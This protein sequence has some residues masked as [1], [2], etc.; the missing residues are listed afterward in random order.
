MTPVNRRISI[1]MLLLIVSAP[2]R[3]WRPETR[4]ELA[5]E[6]LRLMPASLRLVLEKQRGQVRRGMLAPMVDEDGPEHRPPWADGSLEARLTEEIEGLIE[7]LR[8]ERPAFQDIAVRF[9]RV[10]HYVADAGFPPGVSRG[11]ATGRFAHFS[12]FCESRR[13]RFP[14][15][16]YGHQDPDLARYDYRAYALGV[17]RRAASED[18][19]LAAAYARAG[20]PPDPAA[21][22]DRS[23]PFAVGSLAYS[24]SFTDIV[25]V[26]LHVWR[27]A[28]GDVGR[29]PYL[30]EQPTLK[31]QPTPAQDALRDGG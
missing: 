2:I 3:A 31:K 26:W 11:D 12:S 1:A 8:R 22:D 4:L 9:G 6:A 13:E 29:T 17:M 10:A 21:F 15:V 27:Q 18:E 5:D 14:V 30:K 28:G 23:V 20:D 7:A 16:F 24:H 19:Q 25:R